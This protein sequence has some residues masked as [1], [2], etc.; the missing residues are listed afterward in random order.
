MI[1]SST[2]FFIA[3]S[4]KGFEETCV[5]FSKLNEKIVSDEKVALFGLLSSNLF[6]VEDK[7]IDNINMTLLIAKMYISKAK[8]GK[9]NNPT[10]MFD[11]EMAV[12]E[13]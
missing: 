6:G 8:Y 4:F 13:K 3:K 1:L 7:C 11:T 10:K 5:I 9:L 2:C 12:R